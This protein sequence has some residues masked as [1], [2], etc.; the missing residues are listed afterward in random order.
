MA[1][2]KEQINYFEMQEIQLNNELDKLFRENE[3]N[4]QELVKKS[5]EEAKS[6]IELGENIKKRLISFKGIECFL[7]SIH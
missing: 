4:L 2:V 1:Q 5:S 3:E 6:F 7:N